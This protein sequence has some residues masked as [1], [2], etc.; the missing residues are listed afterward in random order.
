MEEEY[1]CLNIMYISLLNAQCLY[2]SHPSNH[3]Q[4]PTI[5]CPVRTWQHI[6]RSAW[7]CRPRGEVD[8]RSCPGGA[9]PST[10]PAA[11]RCPPA[12]RRTLVRRPPP[13]PPQ[14]CSSRSSP[15]FPLPPPPVL[16]PPDSPSTTV[17]QTQP[18]T[19]ILQKCAPHFVPPFEKH[20][21]HLSEFFTKIQMYELDH[22]FFGGV[23][24]KNKKTLVL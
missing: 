1:K 14:T 10:S 3:D 11:A 12:E 20:S 4:V 2:L 9:A 16:S 13:S 21:K 18:I 19:S 22:S 8:W 24:V 23:S 15:C 5:R 6:C 17:K 7:A